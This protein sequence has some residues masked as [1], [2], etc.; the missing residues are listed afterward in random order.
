M[1]LRDLFGK[2][3][4]QG[5]TTNNSHPT[6]ITENGK[7]IP[8][9]SYATHEDLIQY[10]IIPELAGRIP[11]VVSTAPLTVADL[12]RILTEPRN[13]AVK[14]YKLLF[15]KWGTHLE[16]TRSALRQIATRCYDRGLGARGLTSIIDELLVEPNYDSPASGTKYILI[17]EA[18]VKSMDI[19]SQGASKN[20]KIQPLYFSSYETVAFLDAIEVEDPELAFE[21]SRKLFPYQFGADQKGAEEQQQQQQQP[22]QQKK[23]AASG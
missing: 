4:E 6:Y 13:S 19:H 15:S 17:T 8:V 3:T 5:G 7:Q 18:V 22:P 11:V 2:E 23:I 10:G 1:T 16:F 21:L 12:E 9:L 20:A 14:R